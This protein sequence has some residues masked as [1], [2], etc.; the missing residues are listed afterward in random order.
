MLSPAARLKPIRR[1]IAGLDSQGR[2]TVLVDS[3]SPH[4]QTVGADNFGVTDLWKTFS[5]PADNQGVEDPCLGQITLAPPPRG[6]VFRV[7]EFPPDKDYIAT[8]RRDEAFGNLGESGSEAVDHSGHASH[9][10]RRLRLRVGGRDL[11][12]P[13]YNRGA[14][15]PGRRADPT[16]D[17]PRLEQSNLGANLGWVRVDRRPP[18]AAELEF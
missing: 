5:A 15:A 8:W 7:V 12:H 10:L 17:E 6:T 9:R 11:G 4:V 18:C 1:I 3:N 13:R 2:S 16:R 14:V